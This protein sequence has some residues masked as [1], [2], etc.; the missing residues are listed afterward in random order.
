METMKHIPFLPAYFY[1]PRFFPLMPELA[2][3][4]SRAVVRSSRMAGAVVR[5]WDAGG[6]LLLRLGSTDE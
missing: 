4:A 6:G 1:F 3:R 2:V 5:W